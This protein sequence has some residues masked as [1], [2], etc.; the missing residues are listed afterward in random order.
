MAALDLNQFLI[1]LAGWMASRCS[2]A[3]TVSGAGRQLW[4][5]QVGDEAFAAKPYAV[6]RIYDGSVAFVPVNTISVQ[7][8]V[9]GQAAAAMGLAS[10]L[11]AS[12][13]DSDG[14]PIR[15]MAIGSR[16]RINGAD[17]RLPGL[18]ETDERGVSKAAFNV[19]LMVV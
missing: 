19:D 18:V 14:R 6:L 16:W 2:P 4:V 13:L 9:V 12:L 15:M 8:A 7:C 17:V 11:C 1:D 5:N 3:L 10:Q